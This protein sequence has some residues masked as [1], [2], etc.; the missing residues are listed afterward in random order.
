M[1]LQQHYLISYVLCCLAPAA[2]YEQC[3][4]KLMRILE[5][6]VHL[7]EV[8]A[9]YT[10]YGIAS[11]WLQVGVRLGGGAAAVCLCSCC[12]RRA[13]LVETVQG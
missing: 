13:V 5:R 12:A 9:E 1:H 3:Q 4:A 2:G 10:Y 11:P 8:T 6:L 7:R